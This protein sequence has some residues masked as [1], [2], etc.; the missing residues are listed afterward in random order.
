MNRRGP[1][2]RAPSGVVEYGAG[3]YG[4]GGP[5]GPIGTGYRGGGISNTDV[6]G[7]GAN[8]TGGPI[9]SQH[10][11]G[12]PKSPASIAMSGPPM[13]IGMTQPVQSAASIGAA[14]IQP[15]HTGASAAGSIPG[16]GPLGGIG[17]SPNVAENVTGGAGS[18]SM[19][20]R[21]KA[22]YACEFGVERR[23]AMT[24]LTFRFWVF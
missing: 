10:S 1:R 17:S 21:A 3:S 11:L 16:G 4:D 7:G 18:D 8:F 13:G 23:D 5:G 6:G 20:V 9:I 14:G 19:P 24:A 22:L 15:Q 12:G 2:R